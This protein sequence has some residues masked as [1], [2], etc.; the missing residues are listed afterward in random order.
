VQQVFEAANH[1]RQAKRQHA[2]VGLLTCGRCGCAYTAE[3]KKEQY[4]YYRCTGYRG[5]C[6]NTYIR[7]EELARLLGEV[8]K[9]SASRQN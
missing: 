7:E 4:I 5:V 8:V 3:T 6:G 2:F 1:P 9:Q